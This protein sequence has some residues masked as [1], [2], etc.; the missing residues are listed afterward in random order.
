MCLINLDSDTCNF[1]DDSTLYS[2]EHDLQEIVTN[3]ENDLCKLLEW[4]KNTGLEANPEKFQ[5]MFLS[6]KT[7]RRLRLNIERK[8][9]CSRSC[10]TT[11]G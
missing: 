11:R 3:L 10:K 4:F 8:K 6:M 5:L 7:K 9:K 1:A 2:C